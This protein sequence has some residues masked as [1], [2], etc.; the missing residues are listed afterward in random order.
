MIKI[1]LDQ[2]KG[3][4]LS[5]HVQLKMVKIVLKELIEELNKM[6]HLGKRK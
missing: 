3:L 5:L 6:Q 1:L 4:S 2:S